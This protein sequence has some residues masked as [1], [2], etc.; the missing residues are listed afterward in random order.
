MNILNRN[1]PKET[2]YEQFDDILQSEI[3]MSC[4]KIQNMLYIDQNFP[5]FENFVKFCEILLIIQDPII[6]ILFKVKGGAI[7]H[8]ANNSTLP[9]DA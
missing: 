6:N 2:T 3:Q 4:F 7:V 9:I 8:C 1:L 5:Q